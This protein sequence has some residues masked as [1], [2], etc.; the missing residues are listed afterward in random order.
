MN[1]IAPIFANCTNEQ[2]HPPWTRDTTLNV[3]SDQC[4]DA[5]PYVRPGDPVGSYIVDKLE[6]H[7]CAGQ[8]MPLPPNM[9]SEQQKKLIVGWICEGAPDN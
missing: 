3:P 6:G 5:R 2:C 7:V 1:D 8:A 4:C 9:I